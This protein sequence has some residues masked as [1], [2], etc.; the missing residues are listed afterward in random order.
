[1]GLAGGNAD[2]ILQVHV[3]RGQHLPHVRLLASDVDNLLEES[4]Q[5]RAGLAA[6]AKPGANGGEASAIARIDL[7]LKATVRYI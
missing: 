1:M 4:V 3:Q 6:D 7:L 5:A 2:L